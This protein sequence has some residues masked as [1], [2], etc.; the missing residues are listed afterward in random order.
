MP[1]VAS[2]GTYLP[3]SGNHPMPSGGRRR[4]CCFPTRQ[5]AADQIDRFDRKLAISAVW[6]VSTAR[7]IALSTR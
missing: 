4:R 1:Y 7:V 2:I 5:I 3:C 6:P